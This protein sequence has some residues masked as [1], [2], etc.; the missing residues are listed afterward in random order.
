LIVRHIVYET[1]GEFD[2]QFF[3]FR[4]ETDWQ[5]RIKSAGW[6]IV[7]MPQ[8]IVIHHEGKSTG[9][10]RFVKEKWMRKLNLYLPS[11]Y[12]YQKKWGGLLSEWLLWMIYIFGSIWTMIV[13]TLVWL[14]NNVFGWL[15]NDYRKKVNKSINNIATYHWAILYW[16]VRKLMSL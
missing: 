15:K 4:E 6:D 3:M 1:V 10:T 8:A 14:L 16:H 2:E 11:V 12:K 13:L 5:Y 7:Y 9:E